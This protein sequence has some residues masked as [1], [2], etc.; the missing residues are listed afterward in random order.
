ML[1]SPP[2]LTPRLSAVANEVGNCK[3]FSDIGTDHAYLPVYMC[4]KNNCETAIA[5]DINK[6]PLTRAKKTVSAYGL[7]ERIELRLGGGLFALKEN[8]ADA[9]S[10][11]GMGGLLIAKILDDGLF[12]LTNATKIVLQPMSSIP[13]LRRHLY[14]N[15]WKITKEVLSKEDEKIYTIMTVETPDKNNKT[16]YAPSNTELYIGKYLME[17]KPEFFDEYLNKKTTKLRKMICE[18]KKSQS[19]TSAQ[20]IKLSEEILRELERI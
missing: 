12:K 15:G 14:N 7:T 11:A 18:L 20:K 16:I 13:E 9:V 8:E 17:N 3:C 6:G 4:L 2:V 1:T 19:Y 10:I 5:S